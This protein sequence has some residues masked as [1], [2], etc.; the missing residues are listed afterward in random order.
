MTGPFRFLRSVL[1]GPDGAGSTAR[2]STLLIVLFSL[3][4]IT[5][6]VERL[7]SIPDLTGLTEFIVAV[8]GS[9]YGVN[10]ITAA[11]VQSKTSCPKEGA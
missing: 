1:S 10:K 6:L 8:T 2:V 5:Y 7:H 3:G 4:W 11:V 9:L